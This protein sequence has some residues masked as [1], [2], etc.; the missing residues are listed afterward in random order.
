MKRVQEQPV[1]GHQAFALRGSRPRLDVACG[2]ECGHT[3]PCETTGA[4]VIGE[5]HVAEVVLINASAYLS[6]ALDPEL[7]WPTEAGRTRRFDPSVVGDLDS[8]LFELT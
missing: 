2:E 5:E 3:H 1:R 4:V 7:L 6:R 8:G